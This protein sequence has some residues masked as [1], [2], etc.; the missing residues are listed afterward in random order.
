[1]G[2]Y[3]SC[4]YFEAL[5]D[6]VSTVFPTINRPEACTILRETILAPYDYEVEFNNSSYTQEQI[7]E[8][9][10]H[11]LIN[12]CIDKTPEQ[13]FQDILEGAAQIMKHMN[14][15]YISAE[16]YRERYEFIEHIDKQEFMLFAALAFFRAAGETD[17]KIYNELVLNIIRLREINDLI[18]NYT[19]D[20]VEIEVSREEFE[21]A[22]P[23]YK[24]LKSL[25][26]L[27][28]EYNFS[29]KERI[30]LG[31]DHEN[32]ADLN[33]DFGY[34]N[35]LKRL[36]LLQLRKEIA[37]DNI[38]ET[39]VTEQK[40]TENVVEDITDRIAALRG[41]AEKRRFDKNRFRQLEESAQPNPPV[42]GSAN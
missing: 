9:I 26:N 16:D 28:Y 5:Y 23:I 12:M 33:E 10:A 42:T 25:Q 39:A 7:R 1:M 38:S 32:D 35:W 19:R 6:A 22:R 40:E 24:M 8:L 2:R 31:I 14:D 30:G 34:E 15:G 18:L 3:S 21:Q 29:P 20:A 41:M 27:G 36:M 4:T 13:T 17:T 37:M 11:E